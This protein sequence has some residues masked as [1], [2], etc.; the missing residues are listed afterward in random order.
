MLLP[1]CIG[2]LI[3]VEFDLKVEINYK[4]KNIKSDI[5]ELPIE[6]YE[7]NSGNNE[8]IPEI[9]NAKDNQINNKEN[10][11]NSTS[12]QYYNINSIN[13]EDLKN[14]KVPNLEKP[15]N[16]VIYELEDFDKAFFGKKL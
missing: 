11:S 9:S 14:N 16:F 12:S 4:M 15:D 1:F 7:K 3:S 8:I 10:N 2:G 5:L 13:E 6:I